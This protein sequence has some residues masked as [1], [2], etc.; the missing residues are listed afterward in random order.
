MYLQFW[1]LRTTLGVASK[2]AA[3]AA[4][5]I[6]SGESFFHK[7][8]SADSIKCLVP[9]GFQPD[10]VE[11]SPPSPAPLHTEAPGLPFGISFIGTAYSEFDLISFAY[12]FEQATHVRLKRR[13]YAEAVPV[14]QIKDVLP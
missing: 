2:P 3:I 11:A 13:A 9:L 4:Y 10:T 14:T 8:E 5:P 6:I 7:K 1:V 12:A